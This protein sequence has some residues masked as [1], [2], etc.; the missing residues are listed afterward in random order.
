MKPSPL[1]LFL[2]LPLKRGASNG[3]A[4]S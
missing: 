1:S 3:V 4:T 2:Q